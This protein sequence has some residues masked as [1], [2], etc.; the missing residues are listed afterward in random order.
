MLE[1]DIPKIP[2][3]N[4]VNRFAFLGWLFEVVAFVWDV[5]KTLFIVVGLA[6][7]IRFYLVQP[8]YVEG[9]SM[10]PNF[11]NGEYLLID[12]LSYK[13][14]EPKRG[15]VIVFKPQ[16]N[17]YQNYIKR[18]IA[19]PGE[20]VQFNQ[21]VTISKGSDSKAVKLPEPYLQD[22]VVENT[23]GPDSGIIEDGNY[24]VMGDNRT[25]SSDSRV[26]GAVSKKNIIGR[27]WLYIKIAPWKQI[28]IGRLSISIPKITKIGQISKPT[29]P[30]FD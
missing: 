13:F 11:N 1:N 19:L 27:V 2:A 6:F 4:P 22:Q 8:F 15:E 18:V 7:I 30:N 10:D 24:Y 21:G 3:E 26:F 12:E 14:T 28:K 5:G 25:Q 23:I 9:Q 17:T 16:I 29:Y 20:K